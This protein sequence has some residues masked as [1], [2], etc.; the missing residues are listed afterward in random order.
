MGQIM[1]KRPGIVVT[2]AILLGLL[3]P[4][5]VLAGA[6]IIDTQVEYLFG[7]S[8]I[9]RASIQT[10]TP[11]KNVVI[12]IKVNESVDEFAREVDIDTA[13]EVVYEYDVSQHSIQAF[14][15]VTY[16]YEIA[17]QSGD[18]YTSKRFSFEYEDNRFDWQ[19]REESPVRVH[20]YKGDEEFA[21]ELLQVA[22]SGL[23]RIKSLIPLQTPEIIDIYVY[24]SAEEMRQALQLLTQDWV[25]AHADPE[26]GI[27]VVSLPSGP[28][29]VLEME[30]QIPHELMHLLL[31]QEAGDGYKNIPVWLNEGL[32]SAAEL[33]PNPD[34]VKL[35][36]DAQD[37]GTMLA[38]SSLCHVFPKDAHSAYLAYAEATS[39]TR[40]I[41]DS[42]GVSGIK[43]LVGKYVDGTGCE[44][45]IRETFGSSLA[46]LENEWKRDEFGEGIALF[47][48]MNLMPWFLLVLLMLV[49]PV[50]LSIWRFRKR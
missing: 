46:V 27:M 17:T 12:K 1:A 7:E 41:H 47:A 40:Y 22:E 13:D 38:I 9:F 3:I 18:L 6:Q 37:D 14:S 42:Y 48:L 32:A 25:S 19:V 50:G 33:Y 36:S 15:T 10:D 4:V 26:Q 28:D 23:D 43:D 35:L 2:I 29:Q 21:Q 44:S 34:Y 16:W 39:F 30:R 11:L 49:L 24:S 8:I 20:W 45:G 31:Y 5:N